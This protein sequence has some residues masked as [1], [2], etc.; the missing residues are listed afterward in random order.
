MKMFT[1][2]NIVVTCV[3]SHIKAEIFKCQLQY[4]IDHSASIYL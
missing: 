1:F 3:F 2:E 4:P